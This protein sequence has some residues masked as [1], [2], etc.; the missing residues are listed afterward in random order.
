[1]T[2]SL[3]RK[4]GDIPCPSCGGHIVGVTDSRQA[5]IGRS[6]RRDCLECGHHWR[7]VE[8]SIAYLENLEAAEKALQSCTATLE[9]ALRTIWAIQSKGILPAGDSQ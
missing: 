8:V 4:P 7:T 3:T 5:K 9:T 1:M 2:V 6:R